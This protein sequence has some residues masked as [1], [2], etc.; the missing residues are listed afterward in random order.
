MHYY[1][2][3]DTKATKLLF[4]LFLT[5]M[6]FLARDT[7]V[8]SSILGFTKAQLLMLGCVCGAGLVFLVHNRRELKK[9]LLDGRMAVLAAATVVILL[10]MIVKRDWQLMYFSVLIC[11]YFAVFL[12]YFLSYREVARYYVVIMTVLGVYSIIAMWVFRPL[13]VD[14]GIL[15]VPMFCNQL[16]IPFYNFGL[17]F[18]S[19]WY[20]KTRNF[21]IFR[22]P[23]VYQYFII[24]ALFLNNYAV[25]W[26]RERTWWICNIALA[27]TMLT[28]LATGGVAE[29]ALLAL[30]VFIDRKLYKN[31]VLWVCILICAVLLGA[32]VW[33]I[34]ADQGSLY[35][36]LYS[37]VVGKF[38]PGE[39]SF[40][41]RMDAIF[42]DLNLFLKNP[43]FGE[44]LSTV[45]YAAENNTTSTL[46]LCAGF[47]VLGGALNVLAW[48]VLIWEKERKIWVKLLLIPILFLSFNTQNLIADVFFWLFPMM[49]LT[50]RAVPLMKRKE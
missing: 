18:V 13:L 32:L 15:T 44:K 35:W 30:V 42:A 31:K 11:L 41:E 19:E 21:G 43:L 8:T 37:M 38:Q 2:F 5:A 49:A 29:L 20:V 9:I 33:K 24:L 10:P 40:V 4:G 3:P 28:T 27:A 7:L 36:E 23:G 48:L 26:K 14:T 25:S 17:S 39:D 45:L 16:D 12:T 50:E 34:V 1:R 6:L 46:I 22:E 47:G